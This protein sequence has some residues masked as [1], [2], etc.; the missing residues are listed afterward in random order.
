[1]IS[2]LYSYKKTKGN[3]EITF[4]LGGGILFSFVY[5]LFSNVLIMEKRLVQ[6]SF[7]PL[8]IFVSPKLLQKMA[9]EEGL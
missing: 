5:S 7:I 4:C 3:S 9:E 6:V 2:I 8:V 1:M